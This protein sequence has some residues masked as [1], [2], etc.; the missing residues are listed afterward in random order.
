MVSITIVICRTFS[1]RGLVVPVTAIVGVR[2]RPITICRTI[3]PY[4]LRLIV[5]LPGVEFAVILAILGLH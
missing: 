1:E 2:F 4:Q 5:A 3:A